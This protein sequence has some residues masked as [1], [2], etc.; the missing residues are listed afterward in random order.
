MSHEEFIQFFLVHDG[1]NPLRDFIHVAVRALQFKG[2]LSSIL[3]CLCRRSDVLSIDLEQHIPCKQQLAKDTNNLVNFLDAVVPFEIHALSLFV[4]RHFDEAVDIRL[5]AT[6]EH[7]QCFVRSQAVFQ[8]TQIK[9]FRVFSDN[10]AEIIGIGPVR[11]HIWNLELCP[12]F[13]IRITRHHHADF[14]TSKIIGS[15]DPAVHTFDSPRPITE[16]NE[17]LE[18]F[19][20]AMLNIVQINHH[21]IPHF[22]RKVEFF[23]FLAC[24]RV[25]RFLGIE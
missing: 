16:R 24:T 11:Q 7:L 22:Q 20:I 25:R 13:R 8:I 3:I 19:R 15:R 10:I 4:L 21:V 6:L 9:R 12:R 2:W 23:N 18:K 17:L 1:H 14:A 5:A